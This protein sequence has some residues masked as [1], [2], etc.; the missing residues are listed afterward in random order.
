[1]RFDESDEDGDTDLGTDVC[2]KRNG[3]DGDAGFKNLGGGG[4]GGGGD[5][6]DDNRSDNDKY[7]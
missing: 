3:D 1:M 4:G 5:D 7:Q 6:D 2:E